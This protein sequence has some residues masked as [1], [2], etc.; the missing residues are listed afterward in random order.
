MVSRCHSATAVAYRKY[1][2]KGITVCARWRESFAAFLA[3][4]GERPAGTSIDRIDNARGYEPSNC[5]WADKYVQARNRR[6]G[7]NCQRDKTHCVHGHEFT[8]ENTMRHPDGHRY[9][10]TCHNE[11]KRRWRA[12]K[13]AL[14]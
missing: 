7:V 8:P 2:A 5:R 6:L 13:G 1:G 4:M 14:R 9:C 10:R 3:D 12:S 11:R